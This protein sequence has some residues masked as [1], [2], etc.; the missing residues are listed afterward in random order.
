MHMLGRILCWIGFHRW[1][2]KRQ[3]WLYPI[4]PEGVQQDTFPTHWIQEWECERG[5]GSTWWG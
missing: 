1:H 3:W 2:A 4:K 5:C